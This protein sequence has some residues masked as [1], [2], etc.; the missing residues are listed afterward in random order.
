MRLII[1]LCAFL[2][3]AKAT[4]SKNDIENTQRQP[5]EG[6]YDNYL[7]QELIEFHLQ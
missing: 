7:I 1:V 4:L 3:I 6:E 2:S 5:N